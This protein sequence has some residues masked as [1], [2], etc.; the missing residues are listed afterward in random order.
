MK[1]ALVT[2]FL[3]TSLATGVPVAGYGAPPASQQS[4]AVYYVDMQR[5]INESDKGKQAK[6]LLEKQIAQAK[7]KIKEMQKEIEKLKQKLNSPVLS[8]EEKSKLEEELQQKI[9]DLQ[10]YQQDEQIKIMNLEQK[11]TMQIIKEVVKLIKN[12]QKEKHLPMIVDVR[13]AGIIAASPK[14]DLTSTII[15][16]YNQ[17]VGK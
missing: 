15:K 8:K 6:A 1:K 10:R 16:L 17:Q 14:Y 2:I 11:Y 13:E 3:S 5:I 4:F 12:Y 9:R 7:E